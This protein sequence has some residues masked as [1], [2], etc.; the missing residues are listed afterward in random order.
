MGGPQIVVNT[1]V[2]WMRYAPLW[3]LERVPE[4]YDCAERRGAAASDVDRWRRHTLKAVPKFFA[5][6][7]E[8]DAAGNA[9]YFQ[10]ARV[11]RRFKHLPEFVDVESELCDTYTSAWQRGH[12]QAGLSPHLLFP[13]IR[14]RLPRAGSVKHLDSKNK[15]LGEPTVA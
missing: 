6:I 1:N 15:H 10:A 7:Y 14:H 5:E 12:P 9:P 11:L 13:N 2:S 4:I 8:N 3:I